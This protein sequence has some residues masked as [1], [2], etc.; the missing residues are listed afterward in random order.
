M[1]ICY[2]FKKRFAFQRFSKNRPF[3]RFSVSA[4]APHVPLLP[5]FQAIPSPVISNQSPPLLS[6]SAFILFP[7]PKYPGRSSASNPESPV[8]S[9]LPAWVAWR[10]G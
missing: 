5:P 6:I 3:F 1:F 9:F 2:I 10:R 4:K 7:Q 8:G